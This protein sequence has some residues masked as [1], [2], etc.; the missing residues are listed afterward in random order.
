M[1]KPKSKLDFDKLKAEL[2]RFQNE[3][4]ERGTGSV[5]QT[6]PATGKEFR[7]GGY[8]M[9]PPTVYRDQNYNSILS[10]SG[11]DGRGF[12]DYYGEYRGGYPWIDP[13][14]EEWAKQKGLYW[15]WHNPGAI[16]LYER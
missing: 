6:D 4:Y 8:V 16:G 10:V 1:S 5:F 7:L 11:E 14:L 15:D 9:R 13:R 2:E 12:V 3:V